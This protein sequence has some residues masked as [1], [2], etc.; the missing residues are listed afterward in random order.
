MPLSF[1]GDRLFYWFSEPKTFI[2][3][4]VAVLILALWS[5]EW[6]RA[7]SLGVVRLPRSSPARALLV[8]A[9][10]LVGLTAI[11]TLNSPMP[12]WSSPRA[13]PQQPRWR[14]VFGAVVRG[15]LRCHRSEGE[16]EGASRTHLLQTMALTG[17]IAAVYGVL[18]YTGHDPFSEGAGVVS[19][20]GNPIYF[21]SYLIMSGAATLAL[22]GMGAGSRSRA[23]W[24]ALGALALVHG[25]AF[26]CAGVKGPQLGA[27]VMVAL[28]ALTAARFTNWSKDGAPVWLG[29][30][31]FA[32][33]FLV[34]ATLLP[35]NLPDV[36]HPP[37]VG[38]GGSAWR[39]CATRCHWPP[40]RPRQVVA[41]C[42]HGRLAGLWRTRW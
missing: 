7:G 33:G 37:A 39:C 5:L 29:G 8:A 6:L 20:L 28:S 13:G 25:M 1:G 41:G 15:D 9:F 26:F 21:G 14:A 23:L 10:S 40:G 3:H 34:A 36:A 35:V 4:T 42:P 38:I 31:V 12:V 27:L 18:Q 19:T 32:L 2:L 22:L 11:S 24:M 30:V 17:G 16:G